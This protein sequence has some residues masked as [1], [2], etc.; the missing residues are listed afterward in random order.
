[1]CVAVEYGSELVFMLG[2]RIEKV[3]VYRLSMEVDKL[4]MVKATI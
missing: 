2:F 3:I 1:M 4:Q